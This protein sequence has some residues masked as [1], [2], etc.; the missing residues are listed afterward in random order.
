MRAGDATTSSTLLAALVDRSLLQ[1]VAGGGPTRYRMLET[2]RE[3]GLERLAEAGELDAP[4]D[5]R[6]RATSPRS[7]S[8]PSRSLRRPD[9]LRWFALLDAERENILARA[10]P[11]R[12]HR[13]RRGALRLAVDL[14][15]F[16]L[17]AAARRRRRLAAT[18]RSPCPATPTPTTA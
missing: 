9:Q 14:L 8:E 13:R 4:R 11:P 15:W 18:S 7:P 1:V 12:R 10:A 3:Y 16:W 5:A 6:T 17:L 2:I